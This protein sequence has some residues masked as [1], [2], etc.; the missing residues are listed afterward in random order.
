MKTVFI[1]LSAT[2]LS[3]YM[4]IAVIFPQHMPEQGSA[5]EI[6]EPNVTCGIAACG[7]ALSDL[8]EGA[9]Q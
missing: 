7:I 4:A 6:S 1:C 8:A 5:P 2:L 3:G 9:S